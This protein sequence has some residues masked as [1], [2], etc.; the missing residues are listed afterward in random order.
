MLQQR[1]SEF[2]TMPD[3]FAQAREVAFTSMHGDAWPR[4]VKHRLSLAQNAV[5][6]NED[7]GEVRLCFAIALLWLNLVAVC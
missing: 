3:P 4:F 2:A 1:V 6:R 7:R 5:I